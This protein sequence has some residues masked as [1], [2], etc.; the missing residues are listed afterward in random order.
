[1]LLDFFNKFKKNM[2]THMHQVNN[3]NLDEDGASY[4]FVNINWKIN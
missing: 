3:L 1:M 4:E 2:D